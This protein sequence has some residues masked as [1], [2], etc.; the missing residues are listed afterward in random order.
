MQIFY[1]L[2]NS[3]S[4][5]LFE[6]NYS[7]FERVF[8]EGNSEYSLLEGTIKDNIEKMIELLLD[9]YNL[10]SVDEVRFMVIGQKNNHFNEILRVLDQNV[11]RVFDIEEMS[12]KVIDNL[13]ERD[14]KLIKEYGFNF[15]EYN[16]K[17]ATKGIEITEFNLLA[18][19]VNQ[20][21]LLEFIE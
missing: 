3:G 5:C 4:L 13:I 11:Q 15:G 12:K 19:T 1:L 6:K 16:Y 20:D 10:D 17:L 9:E 7:Q 18:F 8:L 21:E 2:V 14:V